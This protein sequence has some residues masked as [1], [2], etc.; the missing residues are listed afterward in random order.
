MKKL[1]L[2]ITVALPLAAL[3][4]AGGCGQRI[5]ARQA[6]KF[7]EALDAFA[8]AEKPDDFLRVAAA[9]QEIIDGGIHS[10]AVFYNQGN[11][12]MRAGK[13]GRAI[14]SYRQAQRYMPL[15]PRLEANLQSALGGELGET[16]RRPL[17]GWVLF[18]QDWISYPGKFTL[19]AAAGV[20]TFTLAVAGLFRYHRRL[21]RR[22]AF[23]GVAITL[24][25]SLSAGYDAF[26]FLPNRHGVVI[27]DDVIARKGPNESFQPAFTHPL[28]EG[29]E[30]RLIERR[31][32]WLL[33]RLSGSRDAWIDG[34]VAVIY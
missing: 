24:L 11:A 15:D 2:P 29:T 18:W 28:T 34:Q 8:K 20:I 31:D 3:L 14:A 9:Y 7:Q 30:F 4:A 12:F 25:L 13:H 1:L 26:R 32:Q 22:L 17:I 23:L 5:D 6:A 33:I 27:D 10:G 19:A 21:F 16:Q